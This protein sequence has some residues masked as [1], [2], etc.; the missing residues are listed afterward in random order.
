MGHFQWEWSTSPTTSKHP[1]H[2]QQGKIGLWNVRGLSSLHGKQP[3]IVDE[4]MIR[5][6]DLLFLTET[7]WDHQGSQPLPHGYQLLHSGSSTTARRGVGII[8]SPRIA[9]AWQQSGA[10]WQAISDRIM[11]LRI[12][13][14]P[15][16]RRGAKTFFSFIY[17][18]VAYSPTEPIKGH[19]Q[20]MEA[21]DDF[22]SDLHQMCLQAPKSDPIFLAGDFN[23]RVG[24]FNPDTAAVL[25]HFGLS[26]TNSNGHRLIDLA[27][28]HNLAIAGTFFQHKIIHKI[29][30]R[31]P[32][33]QSTWRHKNAPMPSHQCFKPGH[34]GHMI[35]HFLLPRDLIVTGAVRDVR[36]FNGTSVDKM[37]Q[38]KA[39]DHALVILTIQASSRP[40]PRG[41]HRYTSHGPDTII[42]PLKLQDPTC[43]QSYT[44]LRIQHKYQHQQCI[45]HPD[46][47]YVPYRDQ[48]VQDFRQTFGV[49]RPRDKLWVSQ[50]TKAA[51]DRKKRLLWT[52]TRQPSPQAEANFKFHRRI[53]NKLIRRDKR[54][55]TSTLTT[56]LN[57]VQAQPN[58]K[59]ILRTLDLLTG[60]RGIPITDQPIKQPDGSSVMRDL[61]ARC[62]T[63]ATYFSQQLNV[64]ASTTP[65]MVE[66]ATLPESHQPS[67]VQQPALPLHLSKAE[68]LQAIGDLHNHR[69]ADAAGLLPEMLKTGQWDVEADLTPLISDMIATGDIPT[70]WTKAMIMPLFK[71]GKRDPADPANYRAIVI[72]D[73]ISKVFTRAIY[74]QLVKELDP[75]I[76][77]TQAGFRKKRSPSEHVFVLRQLMEAAREFKQPLCVAF[78]DI[79]KAYDGIPRAPLLKVLRRY[80]ASSRLCQ[81][82]D[83]L[84]RKT[85]ARVRIGL[86]DSDMFDIHTGVK[87][88]CIPSTI[89]F[90]IYLDFAVRQV[91]PRFQ[92][93]GVSWKVSKP[94]DPRSRTRSSRS[95]DSSHSSWSALIINH[96]LYAD[97]TT[98]IATTY[99]DL[100]HMVTDMNAEF[101]KWGLKI[102]ATKTVFACLNG[103]Q[104][105][106]TPFLLHDKPIPRLPNNSTHT[107]KFLGSLL[108]FRNA[109]STLI[110]GGVLTWLKQWFNAYPNP[111]GVSPA[112]PCEQRSRPSTQWYSQYCCMDVRHGPSQMPPF[113]SWKVLFVG[114]S[115][116]Y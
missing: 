21:S 8:M 40:T 116:L 58:M 27:L 100:C 25:G 65:D 45:T 54:H 62:N 35:D 50:E 34:I 1:H 86:V 75:K 105:P 82:I 22:Y 39:M 28:A 13:S 37:Q 115:R 95:N 101:L 70:A 59:D 99:Q 111:C 93:K 53:T 68:I 69:A 44:N 57:E 83:I 90:N 79:E 108:D 78:V 23:A 32:I 24:T 88:G 6:L 107:V 20:Q 73:I 61:Q 46:Q 42:D 36:S 26:P 41:R 55:F 94:L 4:M 7:W 77:Q 31:N 85:S 96:L 2:H 11:T 113:N 47:V 33:H 16:R 80:G 102:S 15:A 74:N 98:V 30:W 52:L 103:D 9:Q 112:Y 17:A 60:K 72:T 104:V 29:T 49:P 51:L 14:G 66:Q 56:R 97:D 84:Y 71:G 38:Y 76:L 109:E 89:L 87:Q 10:V 110:C 106:S 19:Q 43:Q 81:L 5:Q 12:P 67:Q 92:H 114:P 18:I 63:F 64:T 48:L 91:L 3:P